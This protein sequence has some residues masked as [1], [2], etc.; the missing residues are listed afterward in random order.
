MAGSE[1]HDD[2]ALGGSGVEGAATPKAARVFSSTWGVLVL[3][4]VCCLLWG[5]AFPCIKIGYRV[6]GI[7]SGDTGSQLLF[8]GVL[9]VSVDPGSRS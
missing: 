5:S 8:A 2:T 7:A 1:G 3:N 6:F 4:L 9:V